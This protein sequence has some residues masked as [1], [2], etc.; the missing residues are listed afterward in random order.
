MNDELQLL[1]YVIKCYEEKQYKDGLKSIHDNE[2]LISKKYYEIIKYKLLFLMELDKFIDATILI[3]EELKVPYVPREFEKFLLEKQKEISFILRDK[4]RHKLSIEDLENIDKLDSESLLYVLPYLKDFNIK[5]LNNEF[6][7]IFNNEEISNI[8]KSLLIA[9]L[10][11]YKFDYNFT[12]TKE[13]T[14][15]KFNPLTVFDI[16][17]SENFIYIEKRLQLLGN[18]EINVIE[19]IKRLVITYLLYIY[20]LVIADE[21]CDEIITASILLV[22][23]M[24]NV[25]VKCDTFTKIYTSRTKKVDL[26]CEKLNILLE[27]I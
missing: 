15:I 1:E 22:S 6:Q 16:R 18:I 9:A 20:P 8:V 5:H 19:L 14:L 12:I 7:N 26:I 10:S 4:Q 27:S 24:L 2:N 23:K 3:K 13:N 17:N 11:D 21:Y 25:D